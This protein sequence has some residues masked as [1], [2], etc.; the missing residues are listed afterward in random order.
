MRVLRLS[1]NVYITKSLLFHGGEGGVVKS[2]VEVTV[3]SKEE[4]AKTFVPITSKNQRWAKTRPH[5]FD[6]DLRFLPNRS[7]TS[8]TLFFRGKIEGQCLLPS[9]FCKVGVDGSMFF[10]IDSVKVDS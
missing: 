2:V 5:T 10:N 7:P 9:N 3:N 6:S 8:F 1:Y 4:N